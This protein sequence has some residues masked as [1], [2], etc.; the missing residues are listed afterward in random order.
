[1]RRFSRFTA[2]TLAIAIASFT[3]PA[4]AADCALKLVTSVNTEVTDKGVMLLPVSFNGRQKRLLVSTSGTYHQLDR[5]V[6]DE[7][8]I[9]TKI[10]ST[11]EFWDRM[12][13]R[14]RTIA[15]AP[16]FSFGQLA[17]TAVEFVTE[18]RP[19]PQG[20]GDIA[21]VLA[22]NG[23]WR[24]YDVEFDFPGRKFSLLSQDHCAGQV[25][26]WPAAAIAVV[27]IRLDGEG[28]ILVP[29]TVD[30]RTLNAILSTSMPQTTMY[31]GIAQTFG[32]RPGSADT[33]EVGS[34]GN[35]LFYE[36]RFGSLSIE[37]IT[38]NNPLI[39]LMPDMNK[40]ELERGP[41]TNS[42]L[43]SRYD[44]DREDMFIG[45][46]IL[47]YLHIYIAYK[48]LKLY[49]TAGGGPAPAAPA[50]TGATSAP[51]QPAPPAG[52]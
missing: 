37:G 12:G 9:P 27:P 42:N 26:Y 2:A 35:T 3:A 21:G 14:T 24:S 7:L 40:Y 4:G 32:V 39:R 43:Q 29:T 36:H 49:I 5:A 51:A 41:N 33:P 52:Q 8:G 25:V 50:P 20:P 19:D 23:F 22:T 38:V 31:T 34:S 10:S 13:N 1:M 30:G 17:P 44:R 48:E 28:N 16:A 6:V 45:M 46:S 11:V 15:M 18:S 47:K